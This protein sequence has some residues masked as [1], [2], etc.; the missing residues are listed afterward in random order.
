M[1]L[2]PG[3]DRSRR[4]ALSWSRTPATI[5]RRSPSIR[6]FLEARRRGRA[7]GARVRVRA[8]V[9]RLGLRA[10]VHDGPGGEHAAQGARARL[11]MGG[12]RRRLADQRRRLDISTARSFRAATTTCATSSSAIR[13]QGMKP[14]PVDRAAGRGS[15][16]RRAPRSRRHAAA[17]PVR[18]IPDGELVELAHAVPRLSTHHRLLR[19]ADQEDHRRLGLRRPQAR[20]PA[21]QLRRALLQQ[22]AQARAPQRVGGEAGRLLDGHPQGR[23]RSQPERGGGALPLRHGVQLPQ[24]A[25]HRPVPILRSAV[26]LAGAP[27]GQDLQGHHRIRQQFRRRSR[28]ALRSTATTSRR[29]WASAP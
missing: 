16:Q 10:R 11:R 27:Q 22:G 12:A 13:A 20:R 9:V 17:R 23:A 14:A 19:G 21:S 15:R 28:R 2:A 25:G 4:T 29:A 8:G 7:Q 1:T 6:Q 18:R 26:V 24:P 5:S 3:A